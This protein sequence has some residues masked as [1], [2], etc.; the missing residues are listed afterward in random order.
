MRTVCA[1]RFVP[2][3]RVLRLRD[4]MWRM[5]VAAETAAEITRLFVDEMRAIE[6]LEYRRDCQGLW[7]I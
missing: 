3:A 5:A 2:V 6:L 4:E 1:G 7:L